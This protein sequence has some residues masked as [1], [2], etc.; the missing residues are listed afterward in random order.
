MFTTCV[1]RAAFMRL[2]KLH[3]SVIKFITTNRV[4]TS[5]LIANHLHLRTTSRPVQ[6]S[7]HPNGKLL[8][9]HHWKFIALLYRLASAN[10]QWTSIHINFRFQVLPMAAFRFNRIFAL[11]LWFLRDW[12]TGVRWAALMGLG[13]VGKGCIPVLAY[14][15]S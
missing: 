13:R 9:I 5:S 8:P 4:R 2:R 12:Y 1:R 11:R 6:N 10:K 15:D 7:L 14:S 3:L